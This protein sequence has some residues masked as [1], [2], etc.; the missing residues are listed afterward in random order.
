MT[1]PPIMDISQMSASGTQAD[2]ALRG[3][4]AQKIYTAV[5]SGAYT[6]GTITWTSVSEEDLLKILRELT[7]AGYNVTLGSTTIT[8]TWQ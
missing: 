1:F 4:I 5:Q 6:T 3:L 2:N 8:V 7:A